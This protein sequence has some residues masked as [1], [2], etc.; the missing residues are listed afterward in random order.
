[1]GSATNFSSATSDENSDPTSIPDRMSVTVDARPRATM[2]N[3]RATAARPKAM[4]PICAPKPARPAT[5]ASAAPN[6]APF[7]TP[8]VS[9][10]ANGFLNRPWN[11]VPLAASPAPTMAAA[12]TRGMRTSQTR[13]AAMALTPKSWPVARSA[14]IRHTSSGLMA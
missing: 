4:A 1:M 9:G 14:M 3:A 2:A 7:D 8:R 10:A 11:R 12:S 5:M 13:F 6:P